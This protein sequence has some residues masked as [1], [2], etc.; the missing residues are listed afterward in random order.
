VIVVDTSVW[1]A[2]LRGAAHSPTGVLNDLLAA[3]EVALA[4]PVR[5]ELFAGVAQADRAK[6]RRA[7]TA[8]PVLVPA[9]DIWTRVEQWINQAAEQGQRFGLTDLL[10][11]AMADDLGALVWSLDAD[12]TRMES[13]GF[14]QLY[15]PGASHQQSA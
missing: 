15:D 6:L 7:L 9:E 10:I 3:D 2:T 4:L 11:A 5:L 12:F 1:V 8:L 14:V 13:L